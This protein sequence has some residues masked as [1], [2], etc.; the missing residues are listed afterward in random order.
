MKPF[1]YTIATIT[2]C[3]LLIGCLTQ[4]PVHSN[5]GPPPVNQPTGQ[6][7][8]LS[9]ANHPEHK[10]LS[11]NVEDGSTTSLFS[12]PQFARAYQLTLLP[13]QDAI[14]FAYSP[15][16]GGGRS[17]FDRSALYTLPLH[18]PDASPQPLLG[19]GRSGEFY[20][21]PAVS[22][23]GRYI[24]YVK[25]SQDFSSVTP[26]YSVSLERYDQ[27]TNQVSPL[28]NNAIWPRVSP[29]GQHIVFI[30]VHPNTLERG[31][32]MAK[33]DGSEV[34]ELIPVG[35][36]FDIDTPLFSP[37]G[38]WIYFSTALEAPANS[39]LEQL[40]GVEVAQ[41]HADHNVP[42][43]W[44]RIAT[45]GGDAEQISAREDI[46]LHGSLDP[47]GHFLA[48]STVTGLYWM[49]IKTHQDITQLNRAKTYGTVDWMPKTVD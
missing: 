45:A 8:V 11:I 49:D 27:N 14:L 19:G 35:T 34:I 21:M 13:D 41:A 15:P 43:D 46:I 16:P 38:T 2:Y 22:P 17:P 32:F 3:F 10:I 44:W 48:Y 37:D 1:L 30:G 24:Y 39:W 33:G 9:Q 23:D 29:D 12:V 4:T 47:T 28:L 20:T 18:E 6:L 25:T 7:I 31:L 5:E 36:F 40:L 26:T 42:S